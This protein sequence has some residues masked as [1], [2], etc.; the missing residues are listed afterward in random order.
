MLT[1]NKVEIRDLIVLYS[2]YN[3]QTGYENSIVFNHSK[4]IMER[5]NGGNPMILSGSD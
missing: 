4:F 5:K 3:P 2:L 1:C